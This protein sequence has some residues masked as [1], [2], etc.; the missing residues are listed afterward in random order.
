MFPLLEPV[1]KKCIVA[2]ACSK[3]ELLSHDQDAKE[4]G[5]GSLTCP[6][7]T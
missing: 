1:M 5:V 2:D 3:A 4:D 7:V 6:P